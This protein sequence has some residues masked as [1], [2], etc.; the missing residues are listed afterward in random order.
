MI[1]SYQFSD[2]LSSGFALSWRVSIGF[3]NT[4]TGYYCK[5]IGKEMKNERGING[6]ID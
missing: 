5:C 2:N 6:M 4:T 3:D 1:G